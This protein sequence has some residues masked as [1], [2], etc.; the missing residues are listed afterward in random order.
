MIGKSVFFPFDKKI[1][2]RLEIAHVKEQAVF[3]LWNYQLVAV[4]T[5]ERGCF[6]QC[7]DSS[8]A[9]QWKTEINKLRVESQDSFLLDTDI[10]SLQSKVREA[11]RIFVSRVREFTDAIEEKE[12]EIQP[13]SRIQSLAKGFVTLF[14]NAYRQGLIRP[15]DRAEVEATVAQYY[16]ALK[17]NIHDPSLRRSDRKSVV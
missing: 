5:I 14:D 3:Q 6:S 12:R 13:E 4:S 10:D 11:E 9:D 15:Q 17:K 8:S 16:S 2:D 7:I 1:R